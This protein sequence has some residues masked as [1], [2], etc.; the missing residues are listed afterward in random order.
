MLQL[1]TIS[2]LQRLDYSIRRKITFYAPL[3]EHLD[4]FGIDPITYTAA[5]GG[6]TTYRG[7]VRTLGANIPYFYFSG[8]SPYGL[9][10]NAQTTLQFNAANGLNNANTLVWFEDRVPKSTPSQTNPFDAN[11]VWTGSSN[12]YLSHIT[13]ANS[14][15]ANSEINAI[16]SALLDVTQDIPAPPT[17]P[18]GSVGSF[19]TETPSGPRNSVNKVFTLSQNPDLG[20]LAVYW[21]GLYLKRVGSSPA[22]LEYVAGSTGNRQ[23]TLGSAPASTEA[24]DAVYVVA[25]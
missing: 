15:L 20:S 16:Q 8:E 12:T 13:K 14:V 4:Y 25:A 18:V 17:P 2:N 19:V 1:W 23:L 5:A 22:E 3:T 24:L 21:G 7:G 11:G 6:S 9:L 10:V